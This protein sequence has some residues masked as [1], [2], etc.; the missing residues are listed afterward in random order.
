MGCRKNQASLSP[1]ERQRLVAAFL[2]LK[3]APSVF[4]GASRYDDFIQEHVDSMGP[5]VALAVNFMLDPHDARHRTCRRVVAEKL[6]DRRPGEFRLTHEALILIPI[7]HEGQHR[8]AEKIRGRL[9]AGEQQQHRGRDQLVL[10]ETFLL[11]TRGD[12]QA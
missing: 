4:G 7:A 3:A 1:A 11:I 9:V 6:F 8:R 2:A 10:R 12:Q 5:G